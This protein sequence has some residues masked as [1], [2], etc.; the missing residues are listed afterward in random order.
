MYSDLLHC[1][2]EW[3]EMCGAVYVVVY[4]AVYAAVCGAACCS[5]CVAMGG[6]GV[7]CSDFLLAYALES[8]CSQ[9]RWKSGPPLPDVIFLV[10][11]SIE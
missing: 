3:A 1:L 9:Q 5:V 4:V 8:H 7:M 2:T 10:C 6:G 11:G